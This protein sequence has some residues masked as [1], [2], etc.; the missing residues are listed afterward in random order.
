MGEAIEGRAR[1][2]IEAPNFC[3]V[4]TLRRDG[5]P[6][7]NPVWV[8]VEDDRVVLNSA[9]GRAWPVNVRRDPRANL[10][11]LNMENPYEFVSIKAKLVEDTHDGAD[12]HIDALA[13][14]YLGEERYPFRSDGEVRVILRFEA[15]RVQH[16]GR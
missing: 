15:E 1:E 11:I 12:E 3:M 8:D 2:L 13:M 4:G 5:S 16:F 10:T 14:K 7:V 6:A 9:E